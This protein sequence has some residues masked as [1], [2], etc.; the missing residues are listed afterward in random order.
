MKSE[1]LFGTGIENSYPTIQLPDGQEKRVDEMTKSGH[2]QRWRDDFAL[3][4]ELGIEYLRYGPP[5]Y[6]THLGPD[7]YDWSFADDTFGKLQELGISPIADLCHFGVPE[8]I[9]SFQNPDWPRLFGEY[10]RVFAERYPWVDLFT[11]VNEIFVA[12]TFSAQFGWWNER[13]ATTRDFVT[14][15]KHLCQANLLAMEAII[16][17]R[18]E[19]TFI[20]SEAS[21]YTSMPKTRPASDRPTSSTTSAFSH[22]T[23]PTATRSRSPCTN[24][25]WITG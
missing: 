19:A 12:A 5:Y 2:Y 15:L 7:R 22:S 24:I 9:G 11:P 4:Q 17:V 16:A 8:W 13:L 3:V 6:A 25:C 18:P 20:Q 21:Q 14:A 1:F 23:S 10:A